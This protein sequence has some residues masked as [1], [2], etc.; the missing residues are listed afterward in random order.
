MKDNIIALSQKDLHKLGRNLKAECL[1]HDCSTYEAMLHDGDWL[2]TNL[3]YDYNMI[4]H[5]DIYQV[6]Y[7]FNEY[8]NSGQLHRLEIESKVCTHLTK[9]VYFTNIRYRDE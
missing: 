1:T 2:F 9:F 5:Y 8:G 4:K 3:G 7:A 6:A